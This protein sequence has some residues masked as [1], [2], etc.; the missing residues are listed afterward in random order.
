VERVR[1][2]EDEDAVEDEDEV[3]DVR[4]DAAEVD[5]ERATVLDHARDDRLDG[6]PSLEPEPWV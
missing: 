6:R 5:C 4:H 3:E 2:S 1:E